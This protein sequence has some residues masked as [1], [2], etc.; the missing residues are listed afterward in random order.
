MRVRLPPA[1]FAR[2]SG[3]IYLS[4]GYFLLVGRSF[5]RK[6]GI[7]PCRFDSYAPTRNCE[8]RQ[9]LRGY[10]VQA[11]RLVP[12]ALLA[13]LG[14]PVNKDTVVVGSIPTQSAR[15]YSLKKFICCRGGIGRHGGLK[16]RWLRAMSV[17]IRPSAL[18]VP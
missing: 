6:D 17:Q 3:K 9:W 14:E 5:K 7:L 18:L 16:I 11:L 4:F 8:V 10:G 12:Y 1:H 2:R 15:P 13:Q